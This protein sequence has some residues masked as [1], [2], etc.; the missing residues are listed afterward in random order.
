MKLKH[1]VKKNLNLNDSIE[2]KFFLITIYISYKMLDLW[3]YKSFIKLNNRNVLTDRLKRFRENYYHN[4][5]L[6]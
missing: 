5:M 2:V 3:N 1:L 4:T 6:S